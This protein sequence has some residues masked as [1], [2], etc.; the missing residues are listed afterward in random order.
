M[1]INLVDVVM[2]HLKGPVINQLGGLIGE[3]PEKTKAAATG[4]VPALLSGL[5][6]TLSKPNGE[7]LVSS[8][9]GKVDDGLLDNLGSLLG[10][11][12]AKTVSETG[13][14]LLSTLLGKNMVPNLV[15][16]IVKLF[17]LGSGPAKSLLGFLVPIAFGAVKRFA[18]SK[19]LDVGGLANM[20]RGQEGNVAKAMPSGL[21]NVLASTGAFPEAAAESAI[22]A[23]QQTPSTKVLLNPRWLIPVII[24][25]GLAFLW[26]T[27][28]KPQEV[29]RTAPQKVDVGAQLT[30]VADSASDILSGISNVDAAKIA[31]PKLG[32]LNAQIDNLTPVVSSLPQSARDTIAGLASKAMQALQA[33][34]DR[35]IAIPGVESVI[36]PAVEVMKKKLRALGA[37]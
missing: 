30:K 2:D 36:G 18:R 17:G 24:L 1:A 10:G 15:S 5:V 12:Q 33:N 20:L 9:L 3:S 16:G 7:S 34:I 23:G 32:D 29:A 4:I 37:Q 11:Q 26:Q 35:V 8:F 27:G 22:G 13:S 6:G 25:A 19:G 14:N 31:L 28:K 21:S